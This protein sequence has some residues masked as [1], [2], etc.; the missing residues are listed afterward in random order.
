MMMMMIIP[1]VMV[2]RSYAAPTVAVES[3]DVMLI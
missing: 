2:A 1:E 3:V